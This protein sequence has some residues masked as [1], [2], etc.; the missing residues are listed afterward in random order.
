VIFR[1]LTDK[2]GDVVDPH[3]LN[4]TGRRDRGHQLGEDV[5]EVLATLVEN[6]GGGPNWRG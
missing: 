5:L 6:K 1:R 4:R 3:L 2:H